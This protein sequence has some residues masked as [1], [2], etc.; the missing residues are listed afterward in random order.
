MSIK[1]FDPGIRP[2]EKAERGGA[3]SLSEAELLALLLGSGGA[4]GRTAVDL[5]NALLGRYG[6]LYGLSRATLPDLLLV[7]GIGK[8]KALS[9]VSAFEM[10]K[11]ASD[12]ALKAPSFSPSHVH[13]LVKEGVLEGVS[14]AVF[15]FRYDERGR[16][17]GHERIAS[18]HADRVK[19]RVGPLLA[20]VF[21]SGAASFAL[22]HNHPSG[23]LRPSKE[24]F[25]A[26]GILLSRSQEMGLLFLDHLI[27]G[28]EGYYSFREHGLIASKL[29]SP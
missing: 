2:R 23:E 22:A 20:R 28:P 19:Q 18:G 26:T 4:E 3:A 14:E 29:P 13:S 25:V 16:Y 10:A 6:S 27:V 9:I 15:L 8:A 11:K 24:D 1:D 12:E 17:L 7:K 21:K 5:A